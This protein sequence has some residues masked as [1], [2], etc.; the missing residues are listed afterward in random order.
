MLPIGSYGKIKK[1]I[2]KRHEHRAEKKAVKLRKV[3]SAVRKLTSAAL[4]AKRS[5]LKSAVVDANGPDASVGVT[6]APS[7]DTAESFMKRHEIVVHAEDAPPPFT[8]MAAA[9]FPA[10]IQELLSRFSE[11][12]AIQGASWPMA[13]SGRDVLAISRTGSGK[14]LAFL[15]PAIVRCVAERK[16]HPV[17]A[18]RTLPSPVCLVMAPT[19]ELVLQTT[20]QGELFG[21]ALGVRTVAVYGGAP[22]WGQ[23][24]DLNV[25]CEIVVATPGRMLDML[26]LASTSGFG[27]GGKRP[28]D[29]AGHGTHAGMPGGRSGGGSYSGYSSGD[30]QCC[31]LANCAIL[32]LDEADRML[33]MGFERDCHT[34][35]AQVPKPRQVL[36]FSATWPVGVQRVADALLS[37]RHARVTVGAVGNR[38][39]ANTSVQQHVRLVAPKDKWAA[40]VEILSALRRA[41]APPKLA[42]AANPKC[43]GLGSAQNGAPKPTSG[44]A[45]LGEAGVAAARATAGGSSAARA[46]R[47]AERI[48]IFCNTRRDV[49][50]IGA[51]LAGPGGLACNPTTG[52][53]TIWRCDTISG[54]RSQ[55]EREAAIKAFRSGEISVL[56]AT[57]VA[58]RGLDIAGIDHVINYDFPTGEGGAEEY[59]HRIGRTARAGATGTAHTLF[60]FADS[61]HAAALATL[62]ADAGQPIPEGLTELG[63]AKRPRSHHG[64]RGVK[65]KQLK[66]EELALELARQQAEEAKQARAEEFRAEAERNFGG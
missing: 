54:D 66:D 13:L 50:A 42:L 55:K 17:A 45:S 12:T 61:R 58:A 1:K 4:D 43:T 62:L 10:P 59:V 52:D 24:N 38:L 22:K 3:K 60:T 48:L 44:S 16:A 26:D 9:P 32:V 51:Y 11:P 63:S 21:R 2:K 39:A 30:G 6:A 31:S 37:P 8:T 65:A 36:L 53:R 33:D 18:E 46:E 64:G 14:T 7:D 35:A 23:V 34:I 5:K 25:G 56:V 47:H 27:V 28:V 57:D 20:Q 49:N 29:G 40:F 15:L 41:P 19:R